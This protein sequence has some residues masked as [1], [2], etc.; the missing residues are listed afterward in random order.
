MTEDRLSS[1]LD[2]VRAS[3]ADPSYGQGI[4]GPAGH[5]RSLRDA[6]TSTA[7]ALAVLVERKRV[8]PGEDSLELP[9]LPAREFA[10]RA[11][12]GGAVGL[13]CLATVPQFR[14][15][16]REVAEIAG[17]ALLPVLYKE[18]VL[19]L[20]QV[21]IA[22]RTGASAILLI[23]RLERERRISTPLSALAERAHARG[24]EVLLELHAPEDLK[25]A[26][27]VPADMYG[28]NQRDLATFRLEPAVQRATLHAAAAFRPLLAL[29]GIRSVADA[30]EARSSGADGILVGSAF[31]RA[32]DPEAFLRSLT[33]VGRS[34]E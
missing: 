30:R 12:R 27:E 11:R 3:I 21:D 15:S 10:E 26:K 18:F 9:V 1:I 14:G 32:S 20:M 13:S 19:D 8:S 23:A 22:A 2:Q 34:S 33:R 29:S 31:A 5:P 24:L 4:Q 28:V 16:P 17:A 25:I 7:P 6:V